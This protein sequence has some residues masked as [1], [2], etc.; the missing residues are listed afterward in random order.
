MSNTIKAAGLELTPEEI[1]YLKSGQTLS[2][3]I[4]GGLEGPAAVT[5]KQ[6]IPISGYGTSL[7]PNVANNRPNEKL[8]EGPSPSF[9]G[10]LAKQAQDEAAA[11]RRAAEAD[12]KEKEALT[13]HAL[14]R[15]LSATQRQVKRLSAALKALEEKVNG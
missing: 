2:G 11:N 8:I 13:N 4:S 1:E 12:R 10:S 6:S 9:A 5:P 3:S 15:D 7:R 14:R